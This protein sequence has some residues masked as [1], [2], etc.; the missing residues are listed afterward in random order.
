MRYIVQSN[1]IIQYEF[2]QKKA[3][4][5]EEVDEDYEGETYITEETEKASAEEMETTEEESERE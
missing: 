1:F 4:E 3:L 2:I 5:F